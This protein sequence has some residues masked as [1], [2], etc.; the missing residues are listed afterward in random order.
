MSPDE[1]A[2]VIA[3]S[4]ATVRGQ[5]HP[6]LSADLLLRVAKKLPTHH[7]LAF[8]AAVGLMPMVDNGLASC[9]D[10]YFSLLFERQDKWVSETSL[11]GIVALFL[12]IVHNSD[13]TNWRVS[14]LKLQ[15]NG[16]I[17]CGIEVEVEVLVFPPFL[18]S[19]PLLQPWY[20][21]GFYL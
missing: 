7:R 15:T 18:L 5:R 6:R 21:R 16:K 20:P 8:A 14:K 11:G 4:N 19:I 12:M 1:S 10:H 17:L 13:P 9:L 3:G 2:I